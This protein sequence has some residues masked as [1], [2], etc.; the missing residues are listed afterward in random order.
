MSEKTAVEFIE[1][2][3][4]GAFLIIGS[5]VAGAVSAAALRPYE[6]LARV[7]FVFF[8][9]AAFAFM[10]FSYLLYGR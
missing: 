2:W 9:G 8:F 3:Q 10:G 5:A 4:T 1:E 7:L 6:T